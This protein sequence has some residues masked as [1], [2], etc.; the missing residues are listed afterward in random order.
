MRN[1]NIF[2]KSVIAMIHVEAL[3]GTPKYQGNMKNIIS[4]AIDEAMIYNNTLNCTW[5]LW[6]ATDKAF[7]FL[8]K[9]L[10]YCMDRRCITDD[11][12][13]CGLPN[14]N[15]FCDHRHDQSI[16]SILGYKEN[17]PF[18]DF[19]DTL[20]QKLITLR[21]RSSLAQNFYKR[22][23]NAEDL[24]GFDNPLILVREYLRLASVS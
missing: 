18:L 9:W 6:R 8:D 12:N 4:A 3:P 10:H 22:P 19:S 14:Y 21:P 20:V 16:C 11:P 17:A 1:K 13:E 7:D 24:L 15:G 23:Q 5:S 2:S